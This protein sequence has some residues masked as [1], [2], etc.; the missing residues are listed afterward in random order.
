MTEQLIQPKSLGAYVRCLSGLFITKD[1]PS[2][3]SP[4]ECTVLAALCHVLKD[5]K[6]SLTK[7]HKVELS[8][9]TNHNLQ[10]TTNYINKFRKKGVLTKT[11]TL[12]P[13]FFKKLIIQYG[14][15]SL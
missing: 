6:T 15:S 4:K 11:D 5:G 8:N 1:N 14:E 9:L 13:V 12:H 10:V 2:G 3:L 7:E